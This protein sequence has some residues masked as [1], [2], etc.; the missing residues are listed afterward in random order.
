MSSHIQIDRDRIADFCPEH[1]IRKLALFG[2]ALTDEFRPQSNGD[3]Q[4]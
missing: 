4:V 1:L 3:A 2:S